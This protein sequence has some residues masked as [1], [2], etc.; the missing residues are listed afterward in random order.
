MV[1]RS[2]SEGGP[3]GSHGSRRLL[4]PLRDGIREWLRPG[5]F[6]WE[7]T[8][9]EN[10]E[11]LIDCQHIKGSSQIG[12]VSAARRF[13]QWNFSDTFFKAKLQI[14]DAVPIVPQSPPDP[15]LSRPQ[16][17]TRLFLLVD[18]LRLI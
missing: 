14:K 16:Y 1:E 5:H 6:L 3:L 8:D 17:A 12:S 2:I 15:P 7:A 4:V 11:S 13:V 9:G 10:V 18:L